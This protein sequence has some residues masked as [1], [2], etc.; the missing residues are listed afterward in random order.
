MSLFSFDNTAGASQSSTNLLEGNKIHDVTFEEAVIEDFQGRQNPNITYK[1]IKLKFK[2]EDGTFEHAIFEPNKDR[3]DFDRG[4]R[5]FVKDGKQQSMPT[6]SYV[7]V[8]MLLIKHVI[9]AVRP[10]AGAKID[11]GEVSLNAKTWEELRKVVTEILNKGKG[12]K[13]KIKL[14]TDNKGYGRFPGFFTGINKDGKCYVRD[15]FI[16]NKIG[17]S[18]YEISRIKAANVAVPT[19]MSNPS[20]SDAPTSDLSDINDFDLASL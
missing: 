10:E 20:L 17:F 5:D 4:V 15:N 9:D 6:P 2:N 8:M 16:G 11:S 14:L 18:P 13:T 19:D 3:G 1:V 7:E 12:A